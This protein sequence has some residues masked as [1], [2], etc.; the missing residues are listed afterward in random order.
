[1]FYCQGCSS[2]DFLHLLFCEE[3]VS[4]SDSSCVTAAAVSFLSC[5]ADVKSA[6]NCGALLLLEPFY[7]QARFL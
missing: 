1:M 3:L 5:S 4:A 6:K 7:R 2:K